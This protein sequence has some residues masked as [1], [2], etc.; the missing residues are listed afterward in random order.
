MQFFFLPGLGF[1]SRIYN[2]WSFEDWNASFLDW[3]EPQKKESFQAYAQRM[4]AAIPDTAEAITLVGHSLGGI[5]AQEMASFR[6]VDSL[7]LISSI[8]SRAEL[9]LHFK[10]IQPL[11]IHHLF[12]RGGAIHT[13]GFWGKYRDYVSEEEQT[14]F[15][16]MVG[17]HSN[18]YLQ[19]A[20][21]QLSI[22]REP[23]VPSSTKIFHLHGDRDRTLPSSLIRNADRIIENAGHFMVYK[24][25]AELQALVK[26][27]TGF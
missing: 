9:P 22:W 8:K 1:D 26:D 18:H 25:S 13:V 17:S 16:E 2:K 27:L 6:K 19:W 5:L 11:G 14:L 23:D 20:L 7:V 4:A 24:R 12:T 3:I 15:K 21:R 10:I